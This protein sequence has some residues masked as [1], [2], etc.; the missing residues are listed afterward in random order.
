MR[1]DHF[2]IAALRLASRGVTL[3]VANVA[4]HLELP[5][6][7]AEAHLDRM[8]RA[9][10]VEI[11]VDERLGVIRYRPL[12]L[13]PSTPVTIL[14]PTVALPRDLTPRRPATKNVVLGALIALLIPGFGLFYAAPASIAVVAGLLAIVIGE[15]VQ[16]IPFVGTILGIVAHF[17]L[18]LASAALAVF[19]VRQYNRYGERT[20][21]ERIP[22]LPA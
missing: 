1:F 20:H 12:G 15:A 19:Y 17:A 11:E 10:R 3:T 14:A 22:A 2:E 13:D 4:A 8:A 6:E 7:Q 18:A 9:G 5:P 16:G 21:L